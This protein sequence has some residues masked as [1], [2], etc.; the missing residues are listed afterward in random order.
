VH[1]LE[2][3]THFNNL[4][5]PVQKQTTTQSQ[6]KQKKGNSKLQKLIKTKIKYKREKVKDLVVFK[7]Q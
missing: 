4:N 6:C 3:K 5:F 1:S 7:D 2:G